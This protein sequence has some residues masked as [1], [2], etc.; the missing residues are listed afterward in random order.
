M[1]P[2]NPS[3]IGDPN[4]TPVVYIGDAGK[5]LGIPERRENVSDEIRLNTA[6]PIRPVAAACTQS[7]PSPAQRP[8]GQTVDLD[9]VRRRVEAATPGPWDVIRDPSDEDNTI[10]RAVAGWFEAYGQRQYGVRYVAELAEGNP[11]EADAEFIAAARTDIPALLADLG[12][13]RQERDEAR[14]TLSIVE[15]NFREADAERELMRPVLEAARALRAQ[16]RR[17]VIRYGATLDDLAARGEEFRQV[18]EAFATAVDTYET[19]E[20]Q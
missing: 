5:A 2:V 11:T 8:D 3:A 4:Q 9:E 19:Q 14:A 20:K 7:T 18:R 12:A 17:D 10:I 16:Q 13:A 15:A 1:I 6:R